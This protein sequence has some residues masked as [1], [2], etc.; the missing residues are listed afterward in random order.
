MLFQNEL[1]LRNNPIQLSEVYIVYPGFEYTWA[2]WSGTW[3]YFGPDT[4]FS[5]FICYI[6]PLSSPPRECHTVKNTFRSFSTAYRSAG[7]IINVNMFSMFGSCLGSSYFCIK[8]L[9]L[10]CWISSWCSPPLYVV[11]WTLNVNW[12]HITLLQ[13]FDTS[14]ECI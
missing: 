8:S 14:F 3:V 10:I 7:A 12:A 4:W 1:R 13:T 9:G 2:L 11:F 6:L 5:F